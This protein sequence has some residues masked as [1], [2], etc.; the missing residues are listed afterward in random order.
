MA[1]SRKIV[2]LGR[3]NYVECPKKRLH[4]VSGFW[5]VE[6]VIILWKFWHFWLSCPHMGRIF[7]FSHI[8]TFFLFM[9]INL[10]WR[11]ILKNGCKLVKVSYKMCTS[12][13]T[14]KKGQITSFK[15]RLTAICDNFEN[16]PPSEMAILAIL[17]R[18]CHLEDVI[19][20]GFIQ[21][22]QTNFFAV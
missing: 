13:K 8:L 3:N 21:N 17:D 5:G 2:R 7:A 20:T 4:S 14:Y 12:Y 6:I 18:K 10:K 16:W 11:K 15:G 1:I 19:P 22:S 9:K